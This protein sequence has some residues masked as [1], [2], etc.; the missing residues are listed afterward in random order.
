[1][2]ASCMHMGKNGKEV[3]G[4]RMVEWVEEVVREVGLVVEWMEEVVREVGLVSM[5]DRYE[6]FVW[7]Q[8]LV[9]GMID[10][11]MNV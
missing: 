6:G 10:R 3:Y 8:L 1:M 5:K 9:V 2:H 4:E 11:D 7:D